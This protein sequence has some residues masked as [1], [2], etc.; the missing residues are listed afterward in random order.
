MLNSEVK[1]CSHEIE[2]TVNS[3]RED[4]RPYSLFDKT[5]CRT[6][7]VKAFSDSDGNAPLDSYLTARFPSELAAFVKATAAV[8]GVTESKVV[9]SAIFSWAKSQGFS[10]C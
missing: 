7:P 5:F 3:P 6:M 2:S 8:D 4:F 9:R 10:G 1:T